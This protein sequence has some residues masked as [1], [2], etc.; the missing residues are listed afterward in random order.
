[1]V[2][3]RIWKGK[4]IL[5]E[6]ETGYEQLEEKEVVSE[7]TPNI[8]KTGLAALAEEFAS[9]KVNKTAFPLNAQHL[10]TMKNLK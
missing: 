8:C 5:V 4:Y 2:Y 3:R 9:N 7:Q 1:M 10:K 6:Y